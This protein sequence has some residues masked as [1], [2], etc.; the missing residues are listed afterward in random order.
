ML[1][2]INPILMSMLLSHVCLKVTMLY[3][4]ALTS[5]SRSFY[6][7]LGV[8]TTT[9]PMINDSTINKSQVRISCGKENSTR[10]LFLI[11]VLF[12][13]MSPGPCYY[14]ITLPYSSYFIL[15]SA[16]L[17]TQGHHV[18][19][20]CPDV[21]FQAILPCSRLVTSHH[22]TCHVTSSSYACFIVFAGK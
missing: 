22:V 18:Y 14:Y 10:S 8:V 12:L 11:R 4:Y 2:I 20:M 21:I 9:Y 19:F 7:L 6:H 1:L 17:L 15:I 5:S 13:Q 16:L 3:T